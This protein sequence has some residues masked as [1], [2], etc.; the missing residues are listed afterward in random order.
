M[1]DACARELIQAAADDLPEAMCRGRRWF[2]CG[3][4]QLLL[5]Q[6]RFSC[7][8][9]DG[10]LFGFHLDADEALQQAEVGRLPSFQG[11]A[12]RLL[13]AKARPTLKSPEL[14]GGE[15]VQLS[16]YKL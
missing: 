13:F 4:A 12:V 10:V 5:F 9:F 8:L 16:L 14:L 2:H 3:F 6:P 15:Q 1:A 7:G 11:N